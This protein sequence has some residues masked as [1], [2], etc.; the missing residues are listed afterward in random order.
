MKY[1]MTA[2]TVGIVRDTDGNLIALFNRA[3]NKLDI[4]G[5]VKPFYGVVNDEHAFDIIADRM[6]EI[7]LQRQYEKT[8]AAKTANRKF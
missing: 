6:V 5:I 1:T 3:E 8:A 2:G 7:G 4:N